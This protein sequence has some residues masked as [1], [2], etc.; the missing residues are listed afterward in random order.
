MPLAAQRDDV[1]S[2]RKQIGA[3]EQDFSGSALAPVLLEKPV[4]HT[5]VRAF[6]AS[7]RPN[8]GGHFAWSTISRLLLKSA[9]CPPYQKFN[10][11]AEMTGFRFRCCV[12]FQWL[13]AIRFFAEDS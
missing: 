5:D 1:G 8:N 7:R 4:V 2:R 6:S 10:L 11:R 3:V 9:W 12:W 13:P